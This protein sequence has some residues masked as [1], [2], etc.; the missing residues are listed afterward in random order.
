[1]DNVIESY[2][3]RLYKIIYSDKNYSYV[4]TIKYLKCYFTLRLPTV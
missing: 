1:M 3:S 2:V 4:L